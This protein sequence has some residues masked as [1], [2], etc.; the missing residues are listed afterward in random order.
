MLGKGGR[1][2][3]VGD[4]V[5]DVIIFSRVFPSVGGDSEVDNLLIDQGG[6]VGNFASAVASLGMDVSVVG[7]VGSDWFGRF[8]VS[9]L[10]GFGVDVSCVRFDRSISTGIVFT[11]VDSNGE[12]TMLSYRGANV[13]LSPDEVGEEYVK[14]AR[15]LHVSGYGLIRSPQRDA[16]M[17]C[18]E[19]AK[20][21]NVLISFDPGQLVSSIDRSILYK[22]L[23]SADIVL[24]N[25]SEL[26]FL[27]NSS[28]LMDGVRFLMGMGVRVVG[29]K[30]GREGCLIASGE[31]FVNVKAFNVK[32]VN[33]TGAGD[34]WDAGFIYSFLNGFDMEYA[35]RFANAV[36]ALF[37]SSAYK[38][39]PKIHEVKSFLSVH[40]R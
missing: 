17:K 40:S 35:G 24:P 1:V 11:I 20:R 27:S 34:V 21:D 12:R 38:K 14:G 13:G 23:G 8:L 15:L 37:I 28:D 10:K 36:A 18:I 2:V 6:S 39:F 4:V 7:K 3:S 31:D 30:L 33:V 5:V 19:L 29:L 22:V 16:V 9:R 26:R 32:A 25:V